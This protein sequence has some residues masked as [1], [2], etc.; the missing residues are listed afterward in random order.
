MVCFAHHLPDFEIGRQIAEL[1]SGQTIVNMTMGFDAI[2]RRTVPMRD[3]EV[4]QDYRFMPEPNLPPLVLAEGGAGDREGARGMFSV[5]E[6]R[7]SMPVL[8]A[9]ERDRLVRDHS[10]TLHQAQTIVGEEGFLKLFDEVTNSGV[11]SSKKVA[12]WLLIELLGQL[13]AAQLTLQEWRTVPMRDKEVVQDYR[14]MPEP[15]LPPL[16]LAEGGAGDRE[17]ARGM[18]S[19]EE[20]R[21]SLPVLPAQERD[22]LVRDHSLTLHQ[23]QTIVVS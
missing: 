10:L 14:F 23:A 5:E 22:R 21:R 2:K 6:L 12:S 7:R 18:P 13:N 19:V 1:T 15:N 17:R 20:L 8:P 16:V 4:V 9:Q 3:K 11:C